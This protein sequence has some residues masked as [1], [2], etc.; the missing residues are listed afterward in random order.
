MLWV[1]IRCYNRIDCTYSSEKELVVKRNSEH[2]ALCTILQVVMWVKTSSSFDNKEGYWV[3][4]NKAKELKTI[5]L[6]YLGN[7]TYIPADLILF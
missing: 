6:S 4:F 3:H 5:K 2:F 7:K 1:S